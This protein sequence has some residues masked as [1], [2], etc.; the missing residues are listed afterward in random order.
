MSVAH[1][2]VTESDLT[3]AQRLR[4][5]AGFVV[6]PFTAAALGFVSFPLIELTHPTLNGRQVAGTADGAL[7]IAFGAAFAAVFVTAFGALPLA[8]WCVKRGPLTFRQLAA[9]GGLLG[10]LPF[11]VIIGLASITGNLTD[12]FW[13]P[14]S[15]VRAI[16]IGVAFG[17]AG[18]A[19]FWL[20]AVRGT[21]L[22]IRSRHET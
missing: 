15:L 22:S 6:Q 4:V 21:P 20:I 2:A 18:A 19:V 17:V 7:A 9:W 12:Q 13:D 11:V 3:Q 16:I 8:A 10:N 1:Q 5:L 14:M